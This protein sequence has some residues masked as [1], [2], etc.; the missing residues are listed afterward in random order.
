MKIQS[1]RTGNSDARLVMFPIYLCIPVE[2]LEIIT[3]H[4]IMDSGKPK[5]T[6]LTY[7]G[8]LIPVPVH[9]AG[10]RLLLK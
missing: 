6:L 7:W 2:Q 8:L 1:I 3:N 9:Q 10:T 5:P 4:T